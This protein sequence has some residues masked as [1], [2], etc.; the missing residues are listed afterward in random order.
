MKHV[1][2]IK[3]LMSVNKLI[4]VYEGE[5]TQG[6]TKAV[7]NMAEKSFIIGAEERNIKSKVFNVMVE[8]LQNI[9]KHA[10][11]GGQEERDSIFM[12][13]KENDHYIIASGN[14]IQSSKV[15]SLKERLNYINTLDKEGL[16]EL[17]KDIVQNNTISDKG[18][19]GLGFV[20]MARKTGQK[21]EYSFE[22]VDTT[23]SFFAFKSVI[24]K[25]SE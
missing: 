5:L 10:D 4:L 17:Y 21:L 19:A 11:Q 3:K 20:D 25:L 23:Y 22:M 18:G 6:I 24:T 16:K 7:L 14:Y 13:G 8:C 9:C 15:E 2:D 1:L 12:I